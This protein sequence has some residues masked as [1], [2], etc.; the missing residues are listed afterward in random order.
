MARI[1]ELALARGN[2]T[3]LLLALGAGLL[4]AILVFVVLANNGDSGGGS[5]PSATSTAAVVAGQDIAVGTEITSG[6]VKVVEVPQTLAVKN[7][8]TEVAPVVGQT[9][10]VPIYQGEQVT[11]VKIGSQTKDDGL[12]Y[13]VP[14]GKRALGLEVVQKT[15]VGGLLLPGN[16]VDV[17][18]SFD[19][20]QN[21]GSRVVTVLQ[22]VEVLAVAQKAEEPL[23]VPSSTETQSA[24]GNDLRTS[25]NL[26]K[27][28]DTQPHA[29]T[30]TLA[31]DPQQAE[32]LVG[33]QAEAKSVW[34]SLRSFGDTSQIEVRGADIPATGP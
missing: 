22:D 5:V 16:H 6:M 13:V 34:L 7:A 21:G 24:N 2:R 26:P 28:L 32:V 1:Q 11:S 8:F 27:N 4:A 3:L 31:V 12:Q 15:A 9:A 14:K 25:G 17:I 33:V 10:R 23:P 19:K 18:A 20:D 30:V 29:T